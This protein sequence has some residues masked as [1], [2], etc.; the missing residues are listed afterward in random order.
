[1]FAFFSLVFGGLTQNFGYPNIGAHRVSAEKQRMMPPQ[2]KSKKNIPAETDQEEHIMLKAMKSLS[3]RN[4][5]T[6][7]IKNEEQ[8][9]KL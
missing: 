2:K 4:L 3:L 6:S 9:L 8:K 1:V 5:Q 7:Q